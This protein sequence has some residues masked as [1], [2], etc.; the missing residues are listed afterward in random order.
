MPSYHGHDSGVGTAGT[1]SG[2]GASQPATSVPTDDPRDLAALAAAVAR[3]AGAL[4]RSWSGRPDLDVG[5]KTT[6]TDPVTAADRAS[7]QL[8]SE[9][10]R[11]ARPDDALIGEERGGH[12]EG[13]TGLRWV[14]DPL[15]GTV[16]F[17]YG[18]P[19]HS[20]SVAV[21]DAAGPLAGAVHDPTRDETVTAARGHGAW[22]DG[23]RLRITPPAGVDQALIATGFAYDPATREAQG[24]VL[25]SLIGTVRD[26][27]RFG[28]AALDLA[29][30]AAGRWD[31]YAE[32]VVSRWDY[33][34]GALAVTEAGGR[35]RRW[36]LEL[37][38]TTHRGL[39]AGSPLVHRHLDGWLTAAGG[40]GRPLLDVP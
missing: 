34:A 35:V 26:V 5:T 31:G 21:E 4:L 1:G 19:H 25:S 7:E 18:I 40:R 12:R 16:N 3:D 27:R 28:S 30:V 22:L 36:E 20:V 6:I 29:W 10:L 17:L 11:A 8:I 39:T 37:A 13:T 23:Q 15:D 33:S 38:G 14:V 9:R 24:R 32:L 2:P